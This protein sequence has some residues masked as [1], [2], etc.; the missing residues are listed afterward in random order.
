MLLNYTSISVPLTM[1]ITSIMLARL[2]G[3]GIEHR[4]RSNEFHLSRLRT[5]KPYFHIRQP[6][7]AEKLKLSKR[8]SLEIN[9]IT[10]VVAVAAV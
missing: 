6:G 5:G 4:L 2:L 8:K 7:K 3:S 10:A 9:M 1:C